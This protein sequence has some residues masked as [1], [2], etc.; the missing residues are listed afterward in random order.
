[1]NSS[2]NSFFQTKLSKTLQN[3]TTQLNL[4]IAQAPMKDKSL[5]PSSLKYIGNFETH[6]YIVPKKLFHKREEKMHKK[7]NMTS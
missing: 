4:E 1:M 7:M 3:L 6:L 5:F 2:A